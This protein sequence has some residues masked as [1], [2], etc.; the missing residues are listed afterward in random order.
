M[1][2]VYLHA[3]DA[4]RY[5]QPYGFPFENPNL[6]AFAKESVLFRKAFCIA[7]TCGPSR[8]ALTSGQYPHQIGMYGLPGG[9]GWKF[10]DYGKH[11]VNVLNGWGYQTVLAGVQHE[12]NHKEH[13]PEIEY[14]RVLEREAPAREQDGECYPETIDKVEMFLA[15]REDPRPFFLSIGIDEPHRDN[16]KRPEM[17]LYG[18]SDRFTKT[19]YYDPEKVD[20]RYTAPPPW[21]PDLP[22][23]RKDMESYREG[24]KIMD[25][26]MGRVLYSLKHNGL[27]EDTLVIVTTDHGTEFTG[28]KMTLSDQGTQVFL[29]VRGPKGTDTPF[30]GGKVIEPMVTH[31][32]IFPTICDVL[33]KKPPHPLEGKS[34]V[35]LASGEVPLLHE[36]TFA[37]QTYHGSAEPIRSA[38]SERYKYVRRLSPVANQMRHCGPTCPILEQYG[39]YNREIGTEELYDLYL[40]PWEA[41]NRIA[42]P[43]YA[44]IKADLSQKLDAWMAQTGDPFPTGNIPEPPRKR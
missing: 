38:R 7:P 31:L 27:E 21:L 30:A 35:P 17:G 26:Y 24:V 12:A 28:G 29:M 19:R 42:D 15:T 25:E 32:D 44:A 4:G 36:V 6:M 43:A 8:A 34:L 23:L 5:I 41:C 22:E 37:E 16:L 9:N 20:Y 3:H 18:K 33:G 2:I 39:W 40:D 14:E 13:F 1:N 11:L 10:D